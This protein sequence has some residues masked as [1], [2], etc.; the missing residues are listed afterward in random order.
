[1]VGWVLLAPPHPLDLPRFR[2]ARAQLPLHRDG[3]GV[4]ASVVILPGAARKE[5]R[6]PPAIPT[7]RQR[8]TPSPPAAPSTARRT[9]LPE[10]QSGR[11]SGCEPGTRRGRGTETSRRC[12]SSPPRSFRTGRPPSAAARQKG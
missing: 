12:T 9:P 10:F 4:P 8:A 2:F 5:G 3:R 7:R 11:T 1:R 6:R